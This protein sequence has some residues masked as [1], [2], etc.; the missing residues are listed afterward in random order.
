MLGYKAYRYC[1]GDTKKQAKRNVVGSEQGND[2][3]HVFEDA[4]LS[5]PVEQLCETIGNHY[6][7]ILASAWNVPLAWRE[8]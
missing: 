4:R 7:D 5:D 6:R 8:Q 1:P 2:F 3:Y